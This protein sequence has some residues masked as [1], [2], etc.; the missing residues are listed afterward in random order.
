MITLYQLY[1][2][3]PVTWTI[4]SAIRST[5]ATD[6][7]WIK[8]SSK[9]WCF[10]Q[11]WYFLWRHYFREYIGYPSHTLVPIYHMALFCSGWWHHGN[12]KWVKMPRYYLL[13]PIR[14]YRV[15]I[16]QTITLRQ[17]YRYPAATLIHFV[18]QGTVTDKRWIKLPGKPWCN[19]V[20]LDVITGYTIPLS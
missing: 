9:F 13:E 2:N 20:C 7:K 4:L 14:L 17:P 12:T 15:C 6:N 16:C 18:N 8:L 10:R 5:A 11:G 3:Q 1:R 19:M